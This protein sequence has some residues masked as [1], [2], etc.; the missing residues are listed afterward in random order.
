MSR[1]DFELIARAIR[2][3]RPEGYGNASNVQLTRAQIYQWNG[4][5][6]ELT[7]A[8]SADNPRFDRVKFMVDCGMFC[9]ETK[10]VIR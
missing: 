2:K 1:K 7:D 6:N 9:E 5:V 10:G 3:T 4:V 8:F